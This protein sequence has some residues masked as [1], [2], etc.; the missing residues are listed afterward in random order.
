MI[1]KSG[2][3][4]WIPVMSGFDVKTDCSDGNCL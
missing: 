3:I 2:R 4:P 1:Q